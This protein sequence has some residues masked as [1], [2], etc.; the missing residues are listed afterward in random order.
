MKNEMA[1][2]H[3]GWFDPFFDFFAPVTYSEDRYNRGLQMKTDI[4]EDEKGYTFEIELP[5]IEKKDISVS[6]SDDYLT[7]KAKAE[8]HLEKEDKK[9]KFIHRERFSGVSSRSYYVGEVEEKDIVAKYENGVL[10]LFV[11]KEA[12]AVARTHEIT[13]E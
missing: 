9:T 12:P 3:D 4:K 8:N 6:Y 13:I 7:I 2:Y 11:P 5:G 10:T 1:R